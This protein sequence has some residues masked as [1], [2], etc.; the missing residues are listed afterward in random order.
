MRFLIIYWS[1]YLVNLGIE[2]HI[3]HLILSFHE[4]S[5]LSSVG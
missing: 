5:L 2:I 4:C 1:S 3:F